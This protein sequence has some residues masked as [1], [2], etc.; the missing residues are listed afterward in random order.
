MTGFDSS[1]TI[2]SSGSKV[3]SLT[4]GIVITAVVC[5]GRKVSRPAGKERTLG[6]L[7]PSTIGT[8]KSLAN[9]LA[10]RG[11]LDEARQ[12][13]LEV[14]DR[15]WRTFGP[16]DFRD[17]SSAMGGLLVKQVLR[18]ANDS[19]NPKWKAILDQTRGVCFIATPHIA[20]R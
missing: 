7:D 18:T 3:V 17:T 9:V 1:T 11:R 4:M 12:V 20:N 19:S 14:V 6:P 5:P 13:Y 10:D 2:V 8:L 16:Y 15:C